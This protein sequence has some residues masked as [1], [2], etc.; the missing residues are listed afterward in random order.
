MPGFTRKAQE[1]Q[2]DK[3]IK[4]F[5]CPGIIFTHSASEAEAA[6]R[7]AVK[8][9]QLAN[10]FSPIE[11]I[12]K[13]CPKEQ[14]LSVYKIATFKN[15]TDF[16]TNVA[17]KRN[18]VGRGGVL[19]L[20]GCAR[21]IVKDWCSGKIPYMTRPPERANVH[22]EASVVPA[23]GKDFDINAIERIEAEQVFANLDVKMDDTDYATVVRIC[24]LPRLGFFP[25]ENTPKPGMKIITHLCESP[26]ALQGWEALIASN[27]AIL[28]RVSVVYSSKIFLLKC[29]F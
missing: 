16:V 3:N 24:L 13:R 18:K 23:W 9:E 22:L 12:I 11:L 7:N 29:L 6:L 1:V 25:C 2:L 19:D 14:L 17:T 21:M 26:Y 27:P 10:P 15:A 20:E 5:D 8:V 28:I 4:L